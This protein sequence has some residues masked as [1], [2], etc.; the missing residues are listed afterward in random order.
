MPNV[1]TCTQPRKPKHSCKTMSF[2][3]TEKSSLLPRTKQH[4]ILLTVCNQRMTSVGIIQGMATEALTRHL[5]NTSN[6]NRLFY[7]KIDNHKGVEQQ[8][9]GIRKRK[10]GRVQVLAH[11]VNV[12]QSSMGQR[13]PLLQPQVSV[14]VE[15]GSRDGGRVLHVGQT[16]HHHCRHP[17]HEN[18]KHNKTQ[19][20]LQRGCSFNPV[21]TL[22]LI[23]ASNKKT[24]FYY[25]A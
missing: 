19:K 25:S 23:I 9:E 14:N 21:N 15:L 11:I 17:L 5:R 22:H 8:Q 12:V 20:G 7:I 3:I 6:T 16:L 18:R 13:C 2:F 4:N 10:R 24:T 1:S